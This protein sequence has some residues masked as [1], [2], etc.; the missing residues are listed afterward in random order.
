MGAMGHTRLASGGQAP[1][2]ASSPGR[3]VPATA[4]GQVLPEASRQS[5]R[6]SH[7]LLPSP[8]D[9]HRTTPAILTARL[10]GEWRWPD[11]TIAHCQSDLQLHAIASYS[12]RW[13][14]GTVIVG[15]IR[16]GEWVW[17]RA[18]MERGPR[19]LAW[20]AASSMGQGQ[21]IQ[22][23]TDLGDA[24]GSVRW[25]EGE[26][27]THRSGPRHEQRDTLDR[28]DIGGL[29]RSWSDRARPVAGRDTAALPVGGAAPGSCTPH[30]AQGRTSRGAPRQEPPKAPVQSCR[31]APATTARR[32][33]QPASR[34]W[35]ARPPPEPPALGRWPAPPVLDR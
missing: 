14:D 20:L 10:G 17:S 23:K 33:T 6:G 34:A 16:A 7:L 21:A 3:P 4:G 26:V 9:H 29:C 31:A 15:L 2:Q 24:G 32:D 35:G 1:D 30:A 5:G 25:R 22:S 11:G 19:T 13:R 27:G 18:R 28:G 12:V 8:A